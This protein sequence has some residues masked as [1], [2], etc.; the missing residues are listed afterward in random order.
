MCMKVKFPLVHV[1]ADYGTGDLA[2]AEVTQRLKYLLP[3]AKILTISTPPFST[4]NTGFIIAQ[5]AIYN[6][7]RNLFIYSNTA[8]RTDDKKQR[9]ENEGEKLKYALLDN[10]VEIVAV[11]AGYSFSF[12]RNH[13]KKFSL[14]NVQNQGSQFRS[15]DFYPQ[16]VIG[17][18]QGE[19]KKYLSQ[20][21]STDSIPKVPVNRIMH[22]DGYGNM[23]TTI[24]YK[25][26]KLKPGTRI[27][28]VINHIYQTGYYANG[29][30]SVKSGDLAF[31]PGSSGGNNPFMEV[32]LRAG[33]AWRAFSNPPVETK[34]KIE[35]F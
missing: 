31:A 20:E 29:N 16:A 28:V 4:L 15:R 9:Y 26:V 10:G 21:V 25:S 34:I 5:L 23:K 8:P 12:V 27:R 1:V 32:F 2:F 24:R 18:I 30:F 33:N 3:Q 35:S 7:N 19:H 22:I 17:I 6:P 11:D 13:I 14:I